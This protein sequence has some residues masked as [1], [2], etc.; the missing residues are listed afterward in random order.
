MTIQ[1]ITPA[2]ARRMNLQGKAGA[3]VS[4]VDPLGQAAQQGI[5][6]GDVILSVNGQAVSNLDAVSKALD[7]VQSGRTARLI[8]TGAGGERLV[9]VRKR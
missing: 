9:L 2:D 7:A 5:A 3:V 4:A 6:V 8:V 1:E